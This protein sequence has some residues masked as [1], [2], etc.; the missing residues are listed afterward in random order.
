MAE[1]AGS[2]PAPF[3]FIL[4]KGWRGTSW[5]RGGVQYAIRAFCEEFKKDEPVELFIKFNPTYINPQQIPQ[6]LDN[7]KLPK[8]RPSLRINCG[9]LSD[10]QLNDL[11]NQGDCY[12]CPTRAEAFD[13]GSIEA[14]ATGLPV[15]T[16][17]Y[18]GQ[19]EHMDKSCAWFINYKLQEVKE[20]ISYEEVKW[21]VPDMGHL[22]KIM[23]YVFEHQKETK[24]KGKKALLFA[25]D[26]TWR[27]SAKKALGFLN[28]LHF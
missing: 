9:N 8:D 17:N 15:I 10:K 13:L 26:W 7:L 6:F 11:Y 27:K 18:G 1:V 2:N 4:N 12:L 28:Q 23:R 22:K 3:T 20:D 19:I 24:E 14:M 25:Q 5:D 16:T 21:A